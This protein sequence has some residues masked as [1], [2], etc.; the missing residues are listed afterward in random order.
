MWQG[1]EAL[2]PE[3]TMLPGDSP[4]LMA[5]EVSAMLRLHELG[6][7][8]KRIAHEMGTS[9]NTV[10]RYLKAGGYT[11]FQQPERAKALD[12]LEGWLKERFLA[13]GG[14][15][16]VVRQQLEAEHGL[17]VSLRTVERAVRG[18]REELV[19]EAQATVRFETPP[20]KQLQ[21]DFGTKRVQ[22]GQEEVKLPLCVLTLGYSRRIYV[23]VRVSEQRIE[24]L[25]AIEGA[26][27]HFGGV[28]QELLIDNAKAL[29]EVHDLNARVVRFNREFEAFCRYW[30]VVPKACAPYRARTK[31]KDERSIQYVKGNALAGRTFENRSALESHLQWWMSHVADVRVHSTT[32]QQPLERY[33]LAEQRALR[34]LGG[35]G[36]F[37]VER[38][39]VRH[40][41]SDC[42]VEVDTNH[43]S[44][45]WRYIG[46]RVRVELLGGQVRIV[47]GHQELARHAQSSGRRQWVIDPGHLEGVV[48]RRDDLERLTAGRE[49]QSGACAPAVETLYPLLRPLSEYEAAV[50]GAS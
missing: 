41:Q 46:R 12:G 18:Y 33:R 23:T 31:G 22:L 11:P 43:Y 30:G 19:R 13:H 36:P 37:S 28:P 39:L 4:M 34:P 3:S 1:I 35:R 2:S 15:A 38:E 40:V 24:W 7:G 14:N 45:P 47:L 42:C 10:R 6:W 50:G 21:V 32:G 5:E 48:R 27:E 26:F 17:K 49:P 20:G 25:R 8:V 44:V 9:K 29:V 16:D